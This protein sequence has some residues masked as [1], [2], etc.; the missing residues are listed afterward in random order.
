MNLVMSSS[1]L[2]QSHLTKQ[3]GEGGV[4]PSNMAY[5]IS[6]N[7]PPKLLLSICFA[8]V[9]QL[10]A[11]PLDMCKNISWL[12]GSLCSAVAEATLCALGKFSTNIAG[13]I[14]LKEHLR[15]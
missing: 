15:R 2:I 12:E 5:S 6:T 10:C 9:Q 7:L 8:L 13:A 3:F 1:C 11:R 4:S 14:L